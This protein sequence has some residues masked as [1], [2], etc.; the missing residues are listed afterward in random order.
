MFERRSLKLPITLGVLM[1]V[2]LVALIVGWII[3]SLM[4]AL[5]GRPVYIT[6]LAVGTAFLV[7]ILVGVVMYL[8]LSIKAIKLNRRQSNFMDSVTHELKSPIASL[9]L[10]LQTFNRRNVTEEQRESF[11]RYMLEDVERLDELINHLLDA[12]RLERIPEESEL[13]HVAIERVLGECA[14]AVCLRYQISPDSITSDVE[15]G[16]IVARRVDL[17]IIFRNLVDNAVKYGGEPPEVIV[18]ARLR[19]DGMY[20]TSIRDNGSGIPI[21]QRRKI[22]GRF[23]RLGDEL[24]RQTPGTGLGLYIVR[25]LVKRMKG[26]VRVADRKDGPGTEFIIYLPGLPP[27]GQ[28]QATKLKADVA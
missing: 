11:L 23:T 2:A 14:E 19:S 1:I 9:K 8:I 25:T 20:V 7:F 26:R 4:G 18:E 10:Y 15:P 28:Q 16:V 17:V 21:N 5:E 6:M 27:D 12:A 3:M 24:E 22:F 13:E